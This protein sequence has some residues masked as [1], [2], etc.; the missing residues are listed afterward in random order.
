MPDKKNLNLINWIKAFNKKHAVGAPFILLIVSTALFFSLQDTELNLTTIG[1]L[2]NSNFRTWL[3]VLLLTMGQALVLISGGLD[4]SNGSIVSVGNVILA[5][6]ITTTDEPWHN[7]AIVALV[8][9]FGLAAGFLNGFLTVFLGLQPV[10]V[11]FATSFIYAGLALLM[12]PSPGGAIPRDYT[13]VYR[14]TQYLGIPISLIILV[15][16]LLIWEF[17]RYRKYGHF[18]YAVG[19]NPTAAYTTG[20][21][22]TWVKI[23]T[24]VLSGFL[25]S[26]GAITYSLL[27]GSGFSGSGADM[28]LPSITGAIIGG[29]SFSGGSG[30]L[31]GAVFGGIVLGNIRRIISIIRIDSWAVT[32][33]NA[34]VILFSLATPGLINLL[35][36]KK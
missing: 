29:I 11:T 23:S 9:G 8:I 7:L 14:N 16:F 36:R 3:P 21:P 10:I 35:R 32:L 1:R 2:T 31:L 33:V 13:N 6:Q 27:T 17:F 22:V 25:A 5:L 18:L 20:V 30:S 15:V 4:L 24:Y 26:L 34:L 12:L 28:T 19:G